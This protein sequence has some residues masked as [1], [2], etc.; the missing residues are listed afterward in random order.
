[1][2]SRTQ[3]LSELLDRRCGGHLK[4]ALYIRELQENLGVELVSEDLRALEAT[5]LVATGY[6]IEEVSNRVAWQDFERLASFVFR[7][8]GYKVVHSLYLHSPKAQLDVVASSSSVVLSVDCKHYAR[9]HSPS[10]LRNFAKAQRKRSTL[11][12]T[13]GGEKK[14][15][16]SVVLTMLDSEDRFC[17]GVAIVPI[18]RLGSFLNS[19][20]VYL[21]LMSAS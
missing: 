4:A 19:I 15:V 18:L 11:L 10:Q 20:E 5:A 14:P 17:E 21:P 13:A 9:T 1:M 3:S 7:A 8:W 2:N 12:R 16:Y 6:P